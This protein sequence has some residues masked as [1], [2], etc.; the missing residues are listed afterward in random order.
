MSM[1]KPLVAIAP[2]LTLSAGA[3]LAQSP[4]LGKPVQLS[5]MTIGAMVD[6]AASSGAGSDTS[7]R[8]A[9]TVS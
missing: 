2:A 7:F 3:A 9:V 8:P 5:V 6:T 4:R 1:R